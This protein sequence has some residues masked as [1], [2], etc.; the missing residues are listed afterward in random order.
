MS[1]AFYP[2]SRAEVLHDQQYYHYLLNKIHTAKKSVDAA[3]FII[4]TRGG[5]DTKRLVRKLLKELF[6]A[7][8]RG[9]DIRI[10]VGHS[11]KTVSIDYQD[12]IS[13]RYL[14]K[15]GIPV[16]FSNP[17]DDYSLH[18]KYV[19]I[20][21]DLVITGSHNWSP[22]AFSVSKEDSITI[23]SSDVAIKFKTEFEDLWTTGL[24]ELS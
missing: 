17:P 24:E 12:R 1:Y 5:D 6:Y 20:D 22:N 4:N 3:I 23:Y 2:V 16:K 14:S 15:N 19:I 9:I 13:F 11:L 8:W 21:D 7:K 18:S 10:I